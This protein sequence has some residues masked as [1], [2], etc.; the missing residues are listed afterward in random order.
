MSK[1]INFSELRDKIKG[2]KLAS[3]AAP[4]DTKV[5]LEEL[6]HQGLDSFFNNLEQGVTSFITV[7]F[8]DADLASPSVVIAGEIDSLKAMGA[9]SHIA[10]G[11]SQSIY[12]NEYMG[13]LKGDTFE[14]VL[15][16]A[17]QEE[18]TGDDEQT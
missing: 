11:L 1:V 8:N 13:Q 15:D 12:M 14:L 9:L 18:D 4:I 6:I 5:N 16:E 2:K 17:V 10:N 3:E 7:T